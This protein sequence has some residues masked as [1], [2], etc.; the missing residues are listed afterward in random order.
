MASGDAK[1]VYS[2]QEHLQMKY[3]G[4]GHAD[5]TKWEWAVNQ[6]RDTY[7]SYL[8]HHSLMAYSAIAENESIGRMKYQFLS[9]M[10]SPCGK[11]PAKSEDE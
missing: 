6:H 3:V 8:G 7:A 2:Q 9:K 10:L 1:T 4:T 11:P 5:T